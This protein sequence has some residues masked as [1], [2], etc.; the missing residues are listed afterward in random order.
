MIEYAAS[1]RVEPCRTPQCDVRFQAWFHRWNNGNW[2]PVD[3]HG[4]SGGYR[5]YRAYQLG[6]KPDR[7]GHLP[8]VARDGEYLKTDTDPRAV[9]HGID[10]R[11]GIQV[12][13]P[14]YT[15]PMTVT[16]RRNASRFWY[17]DTAR[18]TKADG[19]EVNAPPV[20]PRG[21]T[22]SLTEQAGM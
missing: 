14:S 17:A 18:R 15:G 2:D 22:A 8:D 12:G 9:I 6:L 13:P 19:W 4:V 11:T 21:R 20:F 3:A 10:S 7:N 16:I 5:L 1:A